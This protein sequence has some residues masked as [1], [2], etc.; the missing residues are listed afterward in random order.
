M[1]VLCSST[2]LSSVHSRASS[3]S[4]ADTK[5]QLHTGVVQVQAVTGGGNTGAVVG[6]TG[7]TLE[8]EAG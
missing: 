7:D 4:K 1:R 6:E 3:A 5:A 8:L 2:Q